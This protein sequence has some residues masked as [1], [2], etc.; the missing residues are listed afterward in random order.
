MPQQ[1]VFGKKKKYHRK[2]EAGTLE[3]QHDNEKT[4]DK[5]GAKDA[6]EGEMND[7]AGQANR[8]KKEKGRRRRRRTCGDGA[9][10]SMTIDEW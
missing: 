5:K 8:R 10:S 2:S 7:T 1:N 4:R 3:D 6:N 9:K